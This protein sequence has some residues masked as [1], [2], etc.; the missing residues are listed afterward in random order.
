MINDAHAAGSNHAGHTVR[1][2][3]LAEELVGPRCVERV[4][5]DPAEECGG[6]V[7]IRRQ[8]RFDIAP[9]VVIRAQ[10]IEQRATLG[11]R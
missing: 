5:H 2:D 6:A 7:V 10:L 4:G 1:A 8:E 11:R 9:H 3:E